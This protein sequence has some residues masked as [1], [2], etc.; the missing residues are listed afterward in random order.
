MTYKIDENIKG[1]VFD[2]D[3]TITD[4]M[5]VHF[6]SW[7][8]AFE[9]HDAVFD[10]EFFYSKAGYSLTAVVEAFNKENNRSLDPRSVADLKNKLHYEYIPR[11][12]LITPVFEVI[13]SYHNILPMAIATG[14]N[15]DITEYTID[16]LSIGKYFE[17]IVS[18]DDVQNSKPH[19]EV[20]LKA[21]QLIGVAPE[22]CEVFE[23][24]DPGLLGAVSAGM[25]ATDI[26]KWL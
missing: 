1:L 19:P 11:I 14:S 6:I 24:G 21:A 17:G 23:D 26:R 5:P 8:K 7:Q 3:G 4:S 18:A 12:D 2:F 10:E 9:A 20:F 16:K 25:K 15:R 13:E 22:N